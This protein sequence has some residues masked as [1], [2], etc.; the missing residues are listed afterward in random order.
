MLFGHPSSSEA[1]SFKALLEL[2]SEAS[3][4]SINASK[5]QLFFFNT[6]VSIQRNVARILGFTIAAL[7][8]KYLGAPLMVS[9]LK[10]VSWRTLLDKLEA[11]LSS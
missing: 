6:P 9:S 5:S 1:K 7:P 4:T 3:G 11:R 2:F 8:S 10:H